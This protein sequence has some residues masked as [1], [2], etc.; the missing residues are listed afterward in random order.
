MKSNVTVTSSREE[1]STDT[2]DYILDAH[3]D[4]YTQPNIDALVQGWSDG[5][6][7]AEG[8]KQAVLFIHQ[9][10]NYSKPAFTELLRDIFQGEYNDLEDEGLKESYQF[11]N[12]ISN[13]C[14]GLLAA[15]NDPILSHC[16]ALT[17][18]SEPEI[19]QHVEKYFRNKINAYL[20]ERYPTISIT[21][22]DIA[23]SGSA[24]SSVAAQLQSNSLTNDI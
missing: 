18:L 19:E 15:N 8:E 2:V 14:T 3:F 12:V 7:D 16:S 22:D 5:G 10:A 17:S 11:L 24:S 4:S 1:S 23:P 20:Q 9:A 6:S 13:Q 21:N